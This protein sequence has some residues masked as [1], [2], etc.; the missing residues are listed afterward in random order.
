VTL[1]AKQSWNL[2]QTLSTQDILALQRQEERRRQQTKQS[3]FGFKKS[4][5]SSLS[6][7]SR[8]VSPARSDETTRSASPLQPPARPQRK[9]KPAPKPPTDAALTV[10]NASGDI[11]D[12]DKMVINHSRN[13]SDSSGY[14]EASVLSDNPDSAA[15]LPETLPRRSRMP[16]MSDTARRLAQTSQSSKSLSNLAVP[17]ET[18][19]R[20]IS[21]TCLNTVG[22]IQLYVICIKLIQFTNKILMLLGFWYWASATGNVQNK[23]CLLPLFLHIQKKEKFSIFFYALIRMLISQFFGNNM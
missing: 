10:Q 6:M 4:K 2:G 11:G 1:Y 13:S 8:S 9:R 17:G 7:D 18:F 21:S 23:I 3:V 22:E 16:G 12:K 20:G 15:R 5:E 14:H 19:N